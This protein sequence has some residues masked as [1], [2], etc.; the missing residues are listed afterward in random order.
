MCHHN[1]T[2]EGIRLGAL[3]RAAG[4]AP[5]GAEANRKIMER[6]VRVDG[7]MVEDREICFHAGQSLL[8]QL[9]KRGFAKINL[10]NS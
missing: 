8:L 1:V 4:L 6:A 2:E 3:L 5:S 9:G 7:V 10:I